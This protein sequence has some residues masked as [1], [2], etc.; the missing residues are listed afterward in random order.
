MRPR[1]TGVIGRHMIA[2]IFLAIALVVGV[3]LLVQAISDARR[4]AETLRRETNKTA[5]AI[6]RIIIGVVEHS[7]LEGDGLKVKELIA[8]VATRVPEA[9]VQVFDQR[10][11]EVFAPKRPPPPP[12]DIP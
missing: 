6:A 9:R 2:K 11:I 7:M 4:E 1:L 12:D 3:A 10:G 8:D 5:E